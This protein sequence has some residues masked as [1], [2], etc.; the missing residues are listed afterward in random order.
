MSD[1]VTIV[2]P[3]YKV[4][5]AYLE[6]SINSII[7]Q[8]YNN[9]EVILI[10]DGADS[11]IIELCENYAKEDKRIIIIKRENRGVSYTR[12]E[13]IEK[14]T[15]KWITFV[16]ADDWINSD[17]V[18][19]FI[20]V[21]KGKD[22][23]DFVMFRNYINTEKC[24]KV[25]K[26]IENSC[27]IETQFIENL[28]QATYGTHE[29][30]ISSSETVWKNFY[31]LDFLRD[32]N[33]RFIENLEVGEDLLFNYKVWNYSKLGYYVDYPMYHYRVNSESVM[34]TD[35]IKLRYKYDVLFPVY[36]RNIKLLNEKYQKNYEGFFLKQIY[37]FASNYY[38]KNKFKYKE[39]KTYVSGNSYYVNS[40]KTIDLKE[41]SLSKKIII[42]L[43]KHKMYLICGLLIFLNNKIKGGK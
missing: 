7:N 19:K 23:L 4:D 40:M 11:E 35:F 29:I 9:I 24:E 5:R 32:N 26:S 17:S 42:S 15:G 28:F 30:L 21:I 1:K 8:T 37:R 43:L 33:I 38:F 14:A 27:Y 20:N 18:E 2:I 10:M 12:N 36:L 22:K 39:F 41:Y 34:N 3:I 6:Q 13:G 25:S 16:D 31:N